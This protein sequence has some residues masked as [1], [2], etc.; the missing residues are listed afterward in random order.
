MEGDVK[1]GAARRFA[2][3]SIAARGALASAGAAAARAAHQHAG[4]VGFPVGKER[5]GSGR[6]EAADDPEVASVTNEFPH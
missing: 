3:R 4:A 6:E 5:E 1:T 2:V